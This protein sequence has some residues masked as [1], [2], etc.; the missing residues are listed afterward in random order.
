MRKASRASPTLVEKLAPLTATRES[1]EL[2]GQRAAAAHDA[3]GTQI[4]AH[5]ARDR[6]AIDAGVL[7]ETLVLEHQQRTPEFQRHRGRAAESATGRRWR[8]AR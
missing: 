6:Q 4:E 3:A 7:L 2:H 1:R 5:G 8:C